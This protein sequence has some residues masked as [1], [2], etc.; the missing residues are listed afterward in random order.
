[1]IQTQTVQA[2]L[3]CHSLTFEQQLRAVKIL[4]RYQPAAKSIILTRNG[5]HIDPED[6]HTLFEVH[7]G[8]ADLLQVLDRVL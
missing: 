3:L 7:E 6:A 8:P 2:L 5:R 4:R 1:M